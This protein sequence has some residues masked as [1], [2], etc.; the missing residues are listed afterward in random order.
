M[1]NYALHDGAMRR[2]VQAWERRQ[3][4]EQEIIYHFSFI[5]LLFDLATRSVVNCGLQLPTHRAAD[6]DYQQR[7]I[8]D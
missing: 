2:K 5:I 7:I 6:N 8:D 4:Q 3:R 1:E